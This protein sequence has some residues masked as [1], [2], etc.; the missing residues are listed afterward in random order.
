MIFNYLNLLKSNELGYKVK[1]TSQC[2][3]NVGVGVF[4]CLF[5]INISKSFLDL[6]GLIPI[7]NVIHLAISMI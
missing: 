4:E 6:E 1:K 7:R 5:Q 3:T 2:K